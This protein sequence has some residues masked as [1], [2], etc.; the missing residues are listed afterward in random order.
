MGEEAPGLQ[1]SAVSASAP[2]TQ[3]QKKGLRDAEVTAGQPW[4][5]SVTGGA[6]ALRACLRSASQSCRAQF[7]SVALQL[8]CHC[9]EG[10]QL[11]HRFH[12]VG[13]RQAQQQGRGDGF[14]SGFSAPALCK[15]PGPRTARLR[16]A[17]PIARGESALRS[18]SA[19]KSREVDAE[20]GRVRAVL[21]LDG[22]ARLVLFLIRTPWRCI[23]PLRTTIHRGDQRPNSGPLTSGPFCF[24]RRLRRGLNKKRPKKRPNA[25]RYRRVRD[26][27]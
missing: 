21:H 24:L 25:T 12:R 16:D 18:H 1:L 15:K 11:A 19:I 9:F 2:T 14:A 22:S 3:N 13:A 17:Q 5:T 10:K 27:I 4:Q 6:A 23:Y 7:R 8:A 26:L 20:R